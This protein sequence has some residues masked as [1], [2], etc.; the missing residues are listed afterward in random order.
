MT[1]TIIFQN[2]GINLNWISGLPNLE[3]VR[4]HLKDWVQYAKEGDTFIV[5]EGINE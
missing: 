2:N 3:Q 4:F 1:Y 5:K